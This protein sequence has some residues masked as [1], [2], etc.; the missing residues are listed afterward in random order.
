MTSKLALAVL[1]LLASACHESDSTTTFVDPSAGPALRIDDLGLATADL[2]GTGRLCL[3]IVAEQD[4]GQ[5]LNGDG[6]LDDG[7]YGGPG[8]IIGVVHVVDLESGSV[9][10]TGLVLGTRSPD[11]D[12]FSPPALAALGTVAVFAV[13]EER[14]GGLDRNGDADA[15]DAVLTVYD[16]AD[17]SL[18]DLG[19]AAH[20]VFLARDFVAIEVP[21]ADQ[22]QDLDGDG[23]VSAD[24]R[25]PFVHDLRT[26]ETWNTGLRGARVLAVQSSGTPGWNLVSLLSDEAVLG[27][28]NGDGDAEDLVLEVLDVD[29]RRTW[30]TGL[31]LGGPLRAHRDRLG[32]QVFEGSQGADLNGDGDREDPIAFV[33]DP[34]TQTLRDLGALSF[35]PNFGSSPFALS[36]GG[37]VS[38][39]PVWLYEPDSDLLVRT[40]LHGGV[41]GPLGDRTVI[42]V[43]EPE[44]GEDLDHNGLLQGQAPALFDLASGRAQGLGIAGE[45]YFLAEERMLFT[46]DEELAGKD[47]N[48]DGDREDS[49]LFLWDEPRGRLTNTRL[50][51]P[52]LGP[53]VSTTGE[54]AF[55]GLPPDRSGSTARRL[56]VLDL[57]TGGLSATGLVRPRRLIASGRRAI[58]TISESDQGQDLNGDGDQDDLVLHWIEAGS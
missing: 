45:A 9:R 17:D 13:D 52:G 10:N 1:L 12:E 35:A 4:Q 57:A 36:E 3:A 49:V 18:L 14:T 34:R 7:A 43:S 8:E 54:V 33:I 47:W 50:S 41:I 56:H 27:D 16:P 44:Q 29:T 24:A 58:C 5:D 11:P 40:E 20:R 48:G 22:G 53:S 26:G 55:L 28:R 23:L 37:I 6:D 42:T 30:N 15:E 51:F 21:E 46:S 32:V 25:V 31:A 19:L 39:P 38:F 2:I